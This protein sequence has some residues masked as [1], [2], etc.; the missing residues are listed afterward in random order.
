MQ[1]QE[2]SELSDPHQPSRTSVQATKDEKMAQD[3][4]EEMK[5]S[6]VIDTKKM[7]VKVTN[8]HAILRGEV[9]VSFAHWQAEKIASE[10]VGVKNVVNQLRVKYR[11]I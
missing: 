2:K 3:I 7:E 10:N 9:G 11:Y 5:D 1:R 4:V 6:D 8:G